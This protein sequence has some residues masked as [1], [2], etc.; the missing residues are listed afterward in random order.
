[1]VYSHQN[2]ERIPR[3]TTCQSGREV[4]RGVMMMPAVKHAGLDKWKMNAVFEET[5]FIV[6][7]HGETWISYGLVYRVK[8]GCCRLVL[9]LEN[10][11]SKQSSSYNLTGPS[12]I[13]YNWKNNNTRKLSDLYADKK[14]RKQLAHCF[15]LTHIILCIVR[16]K[17]G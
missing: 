12:A 2:D 16:V 1:M 15:L 6:H 10:L 17:S 5:R 14:C 11:C 3:Q 4:V 9:D 8:Y 13:I 7:T